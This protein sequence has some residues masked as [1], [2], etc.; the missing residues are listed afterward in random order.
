MTP[1]RMMF[2]GLVLAAIGGVVTGASYQMTDPGGTYTVAWGLVAVGAWFFLRGVFRAMR[3]KGS[4]GAAPAVPEATP[5]P[6]LP[7]VDRAAGPS[8]SAAAPAAPA[9][10]ASSTP[11]ASGGYAVASP[12]SAQETARAVVRRCPFCAEEIQP[13]AILCRWCGRQLNATGEL[14]PPPPPAL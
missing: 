3:G 11:A 9:G 5:I 13:Q 1:Q 7:P 10:T 12:A 6:A 4:T 8:G 2:G 14:P